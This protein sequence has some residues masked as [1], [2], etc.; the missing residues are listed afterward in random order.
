LKGEAFFQVKNNPSMPFIIHTGEIHT[1][2]LGT[3]FK[4][5]AFD[6]QPLVVSVS[7]G[8]VMVSLHNDGQ[9]KTLAFLTPGLK[10]TWNSLT[11]KA[12]Q[13]SVD[14]FNLNQWKSGNMVFEEQ[15]MEQIASELQRRYAVKIDIIDKEI[16]GNQVSGTF[17]AVKT[18]DKVMNTLEIAGKFRYK[19][20][21]NKSFKIYKTE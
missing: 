21:D 13:D 15:T 2:V 7:T 3:S 14:I 10:V 18:I 4:V 1:L 8:K 16:S 19:T 20:I 12:I 9:A 11:C 5:Q 17:P 6:G